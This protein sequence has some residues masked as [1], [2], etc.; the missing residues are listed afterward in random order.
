MSSHH[1]TILQPRTKRYLGKSLPLFHIQRMCI[2][3]SCIASRLSFERRI[4]DGM[5]SG[6][7]TAHDLSRG[8]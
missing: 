8:I 1:G 4:S 5:H 3:N 2:A 6:I 7:A